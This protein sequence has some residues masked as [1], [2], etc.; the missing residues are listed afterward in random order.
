MLLMFMCF[1]VGYIVI[2]QIPSLLASPT[3]HSHSTHQ[4]LTKKQIAAAKKA[5][6]VEQQRTHQ[7][8]KEL[9]NNVT[10]SVSNEVDNLSNLLV[11]DLPEEVGVLDSLTNFSFDGQTFD[12]SSIRSPEPTSTAARGHTTPISYSQIKLSPTQATISVL[13]KNSPNGNVFNFSPSPQKNTGN[14]HNS[15]QGTP[16]KNVV[17]SVI[18]LEVYGKSVSPITT[19]SGNKKST[20]SQKVESKVSSDRKLNNNNISPTKRR[21]PNS[22]FS[23]LMDNYR[24]TEHLNISV[25]SAYVGTP[26]TNGKHNI[27]A[28]P[29][30]YEH[31]KTR[32]ENPSMSPT[33]FGG[34]SPTRSNHHTAMFDE[35]ILNDLQAEW[36]PNGSPMQ[37]PAIK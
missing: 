29:V 17:T 11:W 7:I 12:G 28:S 2:N 21:Q 19:L 37:P 14:N 23:P 32:S 36:F 33:Y 34:I 1:C 35:D 9:N 22:A 26:N 10:N 3:F 16:N 31:E 4:K 25:E 8:I 27:R 15:N 24:S 5:T 18:G 6:E 20:T 30:R 13:L